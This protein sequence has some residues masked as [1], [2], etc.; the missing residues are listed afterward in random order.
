MATIKETLT[1]GLT[2]G[3]RAIIS[4][5]TTDS[6]KVEDAIK[7]L[8]TRQ[9]DLVDAEV[10]KQ[11]DSQKQQL[12]L[13]E[14]SQGTD[15]TKNARPM[16]VYAGLVFI[17]VIHVLIPFIAFLQG[18]PAPTDLK[19]PTEFWWAWTGVVSVWVL[20]R[21][22]EKVNVPSTVSKILTGS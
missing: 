12:M 6:K 13:A 17:L 7:E 18:K 22:Y 21:S 1:N 5:G 10:Q 2:E 15:F 16:V 4:A 8:A 3:V 9:A 19:L 11:A 14:L 20:G